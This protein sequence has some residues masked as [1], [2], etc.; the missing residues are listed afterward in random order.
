M[1]GSVVVPLLAASRTTPLMPFEDVFLTE[2]CTEKAGI[3]MQYS[4]GNPR[5]NSRLYKI[6]NQFILRNGLFSGTACS[7]YSIRNSPSKWTWLPADAEWI[8]RCISFQWRATAV[9]QVRDTLEPLTERDIAMPQPAQPGRPSCDEL[10]NW[11]ANSLTNAYT[12]HPCLN[13][14]C[15]PYCC[16]FFSTLTLAGMRT[17]TADTMMSTISRQVRGIRR[18]PHKNKW[19]F[20]LN[21]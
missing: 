17:F 2:M 1:H 21:C 9:R 16:R 18:T 13:G 15:D 12:T 5:Y 19:R 8:P 7:T 14:Q 4:N 11:E 10:D 6:Y 20:L 3:K